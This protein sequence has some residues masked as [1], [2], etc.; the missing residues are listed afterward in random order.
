MKKL[1]STLLVFALIVITVASGSF[2]DKTEPKGKKF[3]S[4]GILLDMN[5]GKNEEKTEKI[6]DLSEI[7][8][9]QDLNQNVHKAEKKVTAIKKNLKLQLIS[10]ALS[11]GIF[12]IL[13]ASIFK[14]EIE[15]NL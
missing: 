2:A 5:S 12:G 13:N 11:G 14:I 10:K 15:K 7:Y 8:K 1:I 6:Q 9:M 4:S 3:V